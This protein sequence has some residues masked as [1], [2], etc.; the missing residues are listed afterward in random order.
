MILAFHRL[1]PFLRPALASIV[2]QT[3]ADWELLLVD[4]G[5]GTGLSALGDEGRDPRVRLIAQH[6]QRGI[7]AAHNAAVEAARGEFIAFMDYDDVAM[8]QR[9]ERQVAALRAE[10]EVV[11]LGS[12]ALGIDE[13]G[14]LLGPQFTLPEPADQRTFIAYSMPATSPTFMGRREVLRRHPFRPEFLYSGEYDQLTRVAEEGVIKAL[15]EVLLHYRVHAGQTTTS[16]HDAQVFGACLA[17][18]LT[19]RR[20]AGRPEN[21]PE[22]AAELAGWLTAAPAQ[23]ASYAWFARRC[24]KEGFPLL[25]VYHARKL[26]SVSRAPRDISLAGLVFARAA[27]RKPRQFGLLTRLF[28]TGPLRAHGLKPC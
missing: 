7:G 5:T 22:L 13:A 10:P 3:F 9:F 6:R 28:F 26:L 23:P 18:L 17:R 8:P 2:G 25:A 14:R 27:G 11:L 16:G 19:A 1:T 15:P 12:H 21:L 4:D 20:R 24:L